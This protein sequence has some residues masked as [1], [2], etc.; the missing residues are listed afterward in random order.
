MNHLLRVLYK[1][2]NLATDDI[3]ENL[4]ANGK[5]ILVLRKKRKYFFLLLYYLIF[6]VILQPIFANNE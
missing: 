6:V 5:I 3:F 1:Q 2:L 4:L